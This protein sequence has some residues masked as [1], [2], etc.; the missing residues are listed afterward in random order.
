MHFG[1]KNSKL[2]RRWVALKYL[3][4]HSPITA[5]TLWNVIFINYFSNKYKWQYITIA[6]CGWLIFRPCS[7]FPSH[8]NLPLFI[9]VQY[10]FYFLLIIQCEYIICICLYELMS[11]LGVFYCLCKSRGLNKL[12]YFKYV[13]ILCILCLL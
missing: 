3:C 1:N 9:I 11:S 12:F 2:F 8:F 6:T 7:P 5:I 13:Y 10:G 4:V